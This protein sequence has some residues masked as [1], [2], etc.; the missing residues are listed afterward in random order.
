MRQVRQLIPLSV[1][2][3]CGCGSLPRRAAVPEEGTTTA[4]TRDAPG[5]R[6]WTD[7]DLGPILRDVDAAA[8]RER[9]VLAERGIDPGHL[10]PAAY[11]AISGGGDDGAFAAGLLAGWT[12]R[13]DRPM[14]KVVTGISAGALVAPF[15]FLGPRYDSVLRNVGSR[16]TSRDIF[17]LRSL[18]SLI[19]SD[20][21]ADDGPL[22]S[23][24]ERYIT[25][26][27][28]RD[29]AAEYAN[30]RLLFVGTTDLDAGH[31]VIWDMG[32]IAS[33]KDPGAIALFRKVLLASTAIPGVFPPVMID[34]E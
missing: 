16:L 28:M 22:A 7:I 34:V 23:L 14:F 12:Q 8:D 2:L 13:G 32:A 17:H 26:E 21:L 5:T 10:P 31:P 33:S 18:L 15:A 9:R 1:L 29:I 19:T 6:Y 30:G 4:A 24:I 27:V 3:A 25:P 20:G 11:L